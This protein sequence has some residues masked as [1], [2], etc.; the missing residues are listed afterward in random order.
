[1]DA[2]R[3]SQKDLFFLDNYPTAV[4]SCECKG[5]AFLKDCYGNTLQCLRNRVYFEKEKG[6]F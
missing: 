2:W 3:K 5:L 6:E 1:M 4:L